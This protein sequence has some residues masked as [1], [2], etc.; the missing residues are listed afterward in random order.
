ML[1]LHSCVAAA[2]LCCHLGGG[3]QIVLK[4]PHHTLLVGL[5]GK[6]VDDRIQAAV[7]IHESDRYL[8]ERERFQFTKKAVK[9]KV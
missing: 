6:E 5:Y 8:Q 3:V 1:R 9:N 4:D 7:E 2:V